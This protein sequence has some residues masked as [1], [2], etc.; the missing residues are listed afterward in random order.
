[1]QIDAAV[2]VGMLPVGADIVDLGAGNDP[3]FD[4]LRVLV[5]RDE[6]LLA[7]IGA[8][9]EA[10]VDEQ[11]GLVVL[12]GL[13]IVG[14]GKEGAGQEESSDQTRNHAFHGYLA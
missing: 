3:A 9:L 1:M 14:M 13:V 6:A 12:F 8:F 2:A 7:R 10:A 11:V 5:E 4:F